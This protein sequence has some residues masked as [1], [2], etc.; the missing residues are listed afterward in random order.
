MLKRLRATSLPASG[1]IR[2]MGEGDILEIDKD[3][4]SLKEWPRY[5]DAIRHAV[6]K[7]ASV[8]WP[9]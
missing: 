4:R 6:S 8:R 2:A 5:T 9:L 1:D 7:G 3:V